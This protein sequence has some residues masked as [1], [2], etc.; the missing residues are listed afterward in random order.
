M[1]IYLRRRQ[2]SI[3]TTLIE[4]IFANPSLTWEKARKFNFGIDAE[5]YH[6]RLTLSVDVFKEHRYDIL[7]L[8]Q[9]RR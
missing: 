6:Q 7:T 4:G 5:F 8:A 2:E 3:R 1:N 9:Y